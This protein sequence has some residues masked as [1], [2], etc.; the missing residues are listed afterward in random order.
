VYTQTPNGFDPASG[1]L[2]V[3]YCDLPIR[4][5]E[6]AQH[7]C[8]NCSRALTAA[9]PW[10]QWRRIAVDLEHNMNYVPF[11]FSRED[12]MFRAFVEEA[13]ALASLTLFIGM[14]AVWAQV[15][16]SVL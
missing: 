9:K 11:M 13:A 4:V 6:F 12:V 2:I 14:I 5:S 3:L 10:G 1:S 7:P 16:Q 8:S 15:L